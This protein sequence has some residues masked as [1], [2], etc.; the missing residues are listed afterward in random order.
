M[1]FLDLPIEIRE[2]IYQHLLTPTANRKPLP[3]D[4]TT[5]DY[6][7]SLVLYHLNR[8]IYHESRK[9][10]RQLNT[11]ILI[12]T[13]WIEAQHHVAVDGH[14]P[15]LATG[16]IAEDFAQHTLTVSISAPHYPYNSDDIRHFVILLDDLD[17][18]CNMWRY[19]DLTHPGLNSHLRME[20]RFQDPKIRGEWEEPTISKTLQSQLLSPFGIIKNLDSIHVT[21]SPDAY[22]SLV[23]DLKAA[24]LVPP[25][26]AESCLRRA[27]ALK[28]EG[29]VALQA[30]RCDEALELYGKAWLAMH[31][32]V[33]GRERQ[34]HGDAYFNKELTEEPFIG[35]Q[36]HSVRLVLR[37]RLVA[38]TVLAY[39]KLDKPE[40]RVSSTYLTS[41]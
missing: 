32:V 28:D 19:S 22:P 34:I 11:F 26:S 7:P 21:G 20:L 40:V 38:N 25:E 37:V 4:Y 24:M 31:I 27:T 39:L 10:F 5:Y 9:I 29:N 8:Q 23:K 35:Q 36:G 17:A 14:V 33:N 13:P 1:P 12:E 18:F 3:G 15:I 2:Q 41:D 30:G 16:E 6:T